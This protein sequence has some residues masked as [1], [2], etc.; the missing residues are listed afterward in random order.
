MI[1]YIIFGFCIFLFE[2]FNFGFGKYGYF[3]GNIKYKI[4]FVYEFIVWIKSI[5]LDSD[6]VDFLG[7][8]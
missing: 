7:M 6:R 8:F 4:I 2:Y 1:L 5:F 3:M